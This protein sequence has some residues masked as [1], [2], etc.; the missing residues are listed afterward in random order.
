MLHPP[1]ENL[2][3]CKYV[4]TCVYCTKA[5]GNT[6]RHLALNRL[7]YW[8]SLFA[9]PV[10]HCREQLGCATCGTTVLIRSWGSLVSPIVTCVYFS[11]QLCAKSAPGSELPEALLTI[12]GGHKAIFMQPDLPILPS[13]PRPRIVNDHVLE[14]TPPCRWCSESR[15]GGAGLEAHA[16]GQAATHRGSSKGRELPSNPSLP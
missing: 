15:G 9:P 14:E 2:L 1:E 6:K 11:Y 16:W 8:L 4:C 7:S 12:L 5:I 10:S 13:L 3:M